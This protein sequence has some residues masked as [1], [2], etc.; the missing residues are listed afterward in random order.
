M[1]RVHRNRN[2]TIVSH[3]TPPT[4]RARYPYLFP[5]RNRM[6]HLYPQAL[7]ILNSFWSWSETSVTPDG[8]SVSTSWCRA[9]CGTSDQILILSQIC[10]L[11]SVEHPLWRVIRSYFTTDN[12][13]IEHLCGTCG[14]ILLPVC[15]LLS[16]TCGLRSVGRLI[17]REDG[18]AICSAIT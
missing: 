12:Q 10:C 5:P 7:G 18:S 3:L 17:W 14:Q 6:A 16:E 11:V 2:H 4:W 8:Q 1:D 13:S 15:T 9:H